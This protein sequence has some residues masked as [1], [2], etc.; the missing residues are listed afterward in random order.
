MHTPRILT[1]VFGKV[2]QKGDNIMFGLVFNF[3][4]AINFKGTALPDRSGC[5]CRNNAKFFLDKIII[6]TTVS[7]L[8]RVC[9]FLSNVP[10]TKKEDTSKKNS[11]PSIRYRARAKVLEFKSKNKRKEKEAQSV[12]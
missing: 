12:R 1:N 11:F 5:F 7:L 9:L 6:F 4:N 3:I 8:C 10:N 2:G